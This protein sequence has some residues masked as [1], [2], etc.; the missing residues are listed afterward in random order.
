MAVA[1]V[2]FDFDGVVADS[3]GAHLRA[4]EEAYQEC[5]KKK[6]NPE[7]YLKITGHATPRIAGI[8]AAEAGE[9]DKADMLAKRKEAWLRENNSAVPLFPGVKDVFQ[10]LQSHRIPYAIASNAPISFIQHVLQGNHIEIATILGKESVPRPK[11]A[12]DIYL[13]AATKLGIPFSDHERTVVLEDS[14]HGLSAAVSAKMFPVGITSQNDSEEL[15]RA[16]ARITFPSVH[17]AWESQFLLST[18]F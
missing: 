9:R 5:F 4:W 10:H 11:P 18:D 8:L 12:P 3:L 17:H 2:L 14:T 15:M 1:G 16:G 7:F 6:L 13:L